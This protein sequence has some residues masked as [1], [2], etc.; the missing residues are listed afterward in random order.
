MW[1]SAVRGACLKKVR[2]IMSQK[3]VL[4]NSSERFVEDLGKNKS[5][6]TT[7]DRDETKQQ[8]M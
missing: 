3:P 8:K 7:C 6:V 1:T 4:E 2:S 5:Q